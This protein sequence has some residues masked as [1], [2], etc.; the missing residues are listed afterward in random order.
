MGKA[1]IKSTLPLLL[2][3]LLHSL[4]VSLQFTNILLNPLAHLGHTVLCSLLH[5]LVA[6]VI[7]DGQFIEVLIFSNFLLY[8][9]V[10]VGIDDPGV[11]ADVHLRLQFCIFGDKNVQIIGQLLHPRNQL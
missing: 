7:D 2:L 10:D 5:L 8:C 9:L 3:V 6:K 4:T 1:S 11:A